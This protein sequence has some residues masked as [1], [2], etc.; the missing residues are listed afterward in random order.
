MLTKIATEEGFQIG[1]L[2]QEYAGY[3]ATVDTQSKSDQL[4]AVRCVDDRPVIE[5]EKDSTLEPQ[6]PGSSYG[7]V[8]ALKI[9]TGVSEEE[10]ITRVQMVLRELGYAFS[11]H[12]HCGYLDLTERKDNPLGISAPLNAQQRLT[13]VDDDIDGIT[14]H[15]KGEHAAGALALINT[16][17]STRF[18]TTQA[19]TEGHP[20]FNL[21]YGFTKQVEDALVAHGQDK[22]TGQFAN[23]VAR[24]YLRTIKALTG[25]STVYIH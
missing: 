13:R 8:D 6:I 14:L 12:E 7:L 20:A 1:R 25:T 24:L 16:D 11:T 21:D 17:S 22:L 18:N 19:V 23:Q 9:L 4:R 10:A 5:E 15:L 2:P 3:Y